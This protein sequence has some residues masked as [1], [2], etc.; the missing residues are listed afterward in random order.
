MSDFHFLRPL[1]LLLALLPVALWAFK[2]WRG[3]ARDGAF[4]GW[5]GQVDPELLAFVYGGTPEATTERRSRRWLAAIWIIGVIALAGPTWD[6]TEVTLKRER[7]AQ[8]V[9]IDLS[10]SMLAADLKPSRLERARFKARDLLAAHAGGL[11]GLV[12]FAGGAYPIAPLTEDSATLENLL[13]VLHPSLMPEPGARL[14]RGIDAGVALIRQAG[15]NRGGIVVLTDGANA[16]AVDAAT[17]ARAVGITVSILAV[18]TT[19]G[20]PIPSAQGSFVRDGDGQPRL[21]RVDGAALAAVANAGGGQLQWLRND[22]SDIAALAQQPN[23]LDD[24]GFSDSRK[25]LNVWHDRGPWLVLLLLPLLAYG[26]RRG[27]LFA[28]L[29]VVLLSAPPAYAFS[30]SDLWLR[31][32]QQA[33]RALATGD[34]KRA[35][36][37]AQDPALKATA[38]FRQKEFEQAAADFA[39]PYNRG[40]ALAHA[41]KL[42]EALAALDTALKAN[43]DDADTRHNRDLVEQMLKQQKQQQQQEQQQQQ[44]QDSEQNEQPS[45]QNGEPNEQ[46]NPPD[47]QPDANGEPQK[48]ESSAEN[49]APKPDKPRESGEEKPTPKPG[50]PAQPNAKPDGEP[51]SGEAR[52]MPRPEDQLTPEQRQSLEQ[53]LTRVPDDPSGLI[54]RQLLLKAQ[55][56]RAAPDLKEDEQW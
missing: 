13:E 47:G 1:M 28:L 39:D 8:V 31:P 35:A 2:R 6:R 55:R 42:D 51:E 34:A 53:W 33:A 25:S 22:G 20:A 5:R 36:E 12:A 46:K 43:P 26:F 14:D 54:R 11:S 16:R 21:A 32:D 37:V 19:A 17:R 52:P 29:P 40:T 48:P 38:A 4:G 41:G 27:V 44:Q 24:E 49:G 30:F 15:L 50:E 45:E 23:P 7:S 18:G 3:P 10:P 9:V 56:E